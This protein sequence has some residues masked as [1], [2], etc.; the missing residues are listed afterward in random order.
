MTEYIDETSVAELLGVSKA[1]VRGWRYRG[2]GPPFY[3][4]EGGVRYKKSEVVAW[5]EESRVA[6]P[7]EKA[8]KVS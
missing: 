7:R 8:A 2:A 3:K 4:A 1:T 5:L 6:C